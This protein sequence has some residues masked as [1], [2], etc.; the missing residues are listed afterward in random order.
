MVKLERWRFSTRTSAVGKEG[1]NGSPLDH[2]G[3]RSVNM[4]NN[5]VSRPLKEREE[6]V[7]YVA[8]N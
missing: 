3:V 2:T 6:F 8:L 4:V 1:V 5:N 7:V